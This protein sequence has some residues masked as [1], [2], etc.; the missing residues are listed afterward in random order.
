M[1]D[2]SVNVAVA[3]AADERTNSVVVR[4]PSEALEIVVGMIKALD[5]RTVSVADVRVFQLRYADALNTADVINK[6]FGQ[7]TSSQSQQNAP[8]FFGRGGPMGGQ[9]S[10]QEQA[11]RT[12]LQVTAA[13]NSRTPR[14]AMLP[15]M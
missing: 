5:D 7:S 8:M 12:G 15:P 9:G 6:L 1:L 3:A 13:A 10:G 2:G 4:G 11:D 14:A